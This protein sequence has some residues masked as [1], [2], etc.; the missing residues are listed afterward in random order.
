MTSMLTEISFT[1]QSDTRGLVDGTTKDSYLAVCSTMGPDGKYVVINQLNSPKVT[2]DGVSVAKALD[3]G[4]ARRNL[5]AKIITEPAIKTDAEVGDGTT[6]TVFMTYH[7]YEAFKDHMTF[8]NTRYLDALMKDIQKFIGTLII[9]GD[10]NSPQFRNMLRTSSNYEDEIVDKIL[11]IYREHE[12]PN[13]YLNK[14]PMLPADEVKMTKE[15]YFEGNFSVENQ[16][17]ANGFYSIA[18]GNAAMVLVDGSIRNY[19]EELINRLTNKFP[20]N[21]VILL[22]RNFEPEVIQA[23]NNLNQILGGDRILPFKVA[24]AG[25]LGA[26]TINDLGK[27]LNVEAVFDINSLDSN[28]VKTNDVEFILGRTGILMDK[29]NETVSGRADTILETLVPR[30]DA[31]GIVERQTPVGRELN[32]R[33]GRLRA[34]NVMIKVTGVTVSDATE[35]Y[36]RYEDVMKAART[37]QQFGII[38]G[39]GYGYLMAS[40]WLEANEPQQSDEGLEKCR[41]GL[42]KVL[43]AQYEHLTQ[44]DG[45]VENP[46]FID[47]VTG[48]E[49]DTPM[50]VYDNAAATMIALEGAWQTAKTLGKIS[51]VMGRSNTN[52]S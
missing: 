3:F 34:N 42:I 2:K 48:E 52:Y 4:E 13:I 16:I 6:T 15:I 40:R 35:R 51:N 22:A 33:L 43:R 26:G 17:P 9:P 28:L 19:P 50:D 46:M 38:P 23:F 21:P 7:L 18:V 45:S 27:L 25:T 32:R 29:S 5:I 12:S 49:S 39:I 44:N 14:A 10:I 8:K 24:A 30:Y 37:G 1:N 31:L 47:L 36:Y 20:K 11:E 41:V